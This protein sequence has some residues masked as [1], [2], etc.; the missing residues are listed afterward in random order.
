MSATTTTA[1]LLTSADQIFN[2]DVFQLGM[3]DAPC[4]IVF[5]YSNF[6]KEKASRTLRVTAPA[7]M[8]TV[9]TAFDE[10][11]PTLNNITR[12]NDGYENNVA[13]KVGTYTCVVD[14]D[15][16]TV[17]WATLGRNTHCI[18][19]VK[20]TPY[21]M[22]GNAGV[23]LRVVAMRVTDFVRPTTSYTYQ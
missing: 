15:G 6:D 16:D 5:D 10:A 2:T 20:P 12:R 19:I 14:S 18:L 11:N 13:I 21:K 23:S 7:D 3:L 8:T 1:P 22:S 17:D 9:L 4:R